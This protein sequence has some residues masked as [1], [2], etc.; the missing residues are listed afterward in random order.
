MLLRSSFETKVL[1]AF[2]AAALVVAAVTAMGWKLADDAE[3]ATR[4]VTHTHQVLGN[5]AHIRANTL[6]IEMSTQSFRVTGDPV[7]ITERDAMAEAREAMLGQLRQLTADNPLQQ[8]RWALL[9]K[10]VDERLAI[11]RHVENLRKTQ[12]QAAASAFVAAAPLQ[13]TRERV[14]ELLR[15]L[16]FEE[17]ALLKARTD[18]QLRTRRFLLV[19]NGAVALVLLGVLGGAYALIWRQLRETRVTQRALADS[20]ESLAT[21]M[22]SIGDAVLA[23]DTEGRITRMNPVA[24]R[25]T[26]WPFELAR[27]LPIDVVFRI[28]NEMSREPAVVPVAR[29]LATGLVQE[30]ANH[31]TLIA[32]DGRECPIADS[33]A[34][35]RT[36]DGEVTGVVLV[37][38]DET[39]HRQA[40]RQIAEH[41]TLLEQR[42]QER[43]A[44]L[45]ASEDHL[46]SVIN[47]VPAV[48]AYVDAEQ[49][50][51]YTNLQHRALYAPGRDDVN[52]RT[53]REILG[54]ERYAQA[55]PMIAQVLAGQRQSYDWE[56]FP[57]MWQAIDCIPKRDGEG[58]V[59][60]YY[61]LGTDITAR[62][63]AQ[64]QIQTLNA[65]LERHVQQLEH[66]TRA[67]RTLSAGNR[68]MLRSTDESDLLAGMCE[69]IVSVGE[70]AMAAVWYQPPDKDPALLQPVAESISPTGQPWLR[71]LHAR[72]KAGEEGEGGQGVLGDAFRSGLASVGR[73]GVPPG[74]DGPAWLADMPAAASVLAC[75]LRVDGLVIGVLAICSH[76]KDTFEPDE[77]SF[78]AESADDLAFGVTT[79]RHRVEQQNVQA[80]M[81]R[82]SRFDALTGLPNEAQFTETM[83]ASIEA[84]QPFAVLQTNVERLSEI[85]DALGFSYGDQLLREVGARLTRAVPVAAM[86]GRLRGDEFAILLPGCKADGVVAMVKAL[87]AVLA[88]PFPMADISMD[89]SGTT[90]VALYPQH[91]ATPHDLYRH[92]DMAMHQAKKAGVGHVVFDPTQNQNHNQA[93]RLHMAGE[94]RRAIESGDLSLYLQPK[95]EM[96]TGRVCG[97]EGLVRWRHA[98]RGMVMPNDFI[99]LAEH[100]GLIK[101]LTEWVIEAALRLNHGWATRGCA[102]PIA[103]NLSARNLRDESLLQTIR[104]LQATWGAAP[105]LLELE[106]T[107]STVMEDA[108]HALRML[109]GLRELGIALYIDDFGTGY[110]SLSYLQKLPVEYIKIDQ[111]FVRDMS[112]R[113]DSAVIVRST[114][115]LVHDLGRK[116]VAEGIETQEHWDQLAALGCDIGQGYFIARPMP[117]QDFP[118]WVAGFV[119][120]T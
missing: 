105:G 40:Q 21:T 7:H 15:A 102:L 68:T 98:Q 78:L 69:A 39:L 1:A 17:T 35:I 56:P 58:Q 97:A 93:Q 55:G 51:V 28:I 25:L 32:R 107:E 74:P 57:G 92:M 83:A 49:R 118:G 53:V 50:Y 37:F 2:V 95:I 59:H 109:H 120:P 5:V 63:Q 62:K 71:A 8:E 117:A 14:H 81:Q 90:G 4:W 94:L 22:H 86:V 66:T 18:D 16:E 99:G 38:R 116:V 48:L 64:E 27:G 43:T 65:E 20:E 80:A 24:E 34:P 104:Q 79:L 103:V 113:K 84:G 30:L 72:W 19:A 61:V 101:P 29:V 114:I 112:V 115:D 88:Q 54:E 91:G 9:R 33:A 100:T 41:N 67:L 23:T 60:G 52:G 42:V 36:A 89:I 73:G 70:Y 26:G 76:R 13:K 96:A 47:N 6:Q 12:G 119:P 46:Y 82:L 77:I 3:E 44:Q 85:N 108:E 31:T 87:D 75:P 111:S 106:I 110:S 10:M 11:S 45:H